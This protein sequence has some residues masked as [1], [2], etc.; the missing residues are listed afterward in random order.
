MA[1]SGVDALRA[2]A[3]SPEAPVAARGFAEPTA[4]AAAAA[5]PASLSE[6]RRTVGVHGHGDGV[7]PRSG[8]SY[9]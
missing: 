9:F 8:Q 1:R 2:V 7:S 3:Q 6:R 5:A 4:A